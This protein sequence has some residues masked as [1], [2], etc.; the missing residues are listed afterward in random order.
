MRRYWFAWV[1]GAA[2]V[3]AGRPAG[4]APAAAAAPAE[5]AP[6]AATREVDLA[7]AV[8]MAMAN[9]PRV[10]SAQASVQEG[11]AGLRQ[12]KAAAMPHLTAAAGYSWLQD[13]PQ[14]QVSPLGTMVFGTT[15][16]TNAGLTLQYPLYT[17]GKLG[18]MRH[19]A[20]AGVDALLARQD[21]VAQQA[22]LHAAERYF[23][24]LKADQMIGVM[25]EQ[26]KALEA[27]RAAV[28]KMRAAGVVS[29]ID[30]LRTDVA[31]AGAREGLVKARSARDVGAAALAE[32]MG[33]PAET[34]LRLSGKY[35]EPQL[36]AKLEEA[37][38]EGLRSRPEVRETQAGVAAADS[39]I[40][41]ARSAERPQVGAF[42][43]SD[44]DRP[45]YLPRTGTWSA[46]VALTYNLFDGGAAKA[47]V[48]AAKAE[49]ARVEAGQSELENG[50]RLD[51]TQRFR[52]VQSARERIVTTQAAVAAAEESQRLATIGYEN[53]VTPLTDLL[54]SQADLTRAR[55][56]VLSAQYDL[57]A[58]EARLQTAMGR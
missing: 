42:L 37:I 45:S 17:G 8:K 19:Q 51:V 21:S 43:A 48:A 3:V 6:A 39:A 52:E 30:L 20:E 12:A 28:E 33:L 53:H 40:K 18:A 27:Q 44:F 7:D 29:K 2:V 1:L 5:G 46:G 22:G 36:P 11:L 13:P 57:R 14:F 50:I 38:A 58:A 31:L 34:P 10:K 26:I 54:Q 16:N 35:D 49:R 24:V 56:D 9:H 4:A 32:A 25:D 15:D 41:V 55:S 47:Q 23:D